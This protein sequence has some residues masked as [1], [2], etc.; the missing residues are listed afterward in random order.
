MTSTPTPTPPMPPPEDESLF[1]HVGRVCKNSVTKCFGCVQ[2][3]DEYAKIK[4]K[5]HQIDSRK[6]AFGVAYMNLILEKA[7]EEALNACLEKAQAEIA[8]FAEE[9]QVLQAEIDRVNQST[10]EKIVVKPGTVAAS[11]AVPAAAAAAAV[12]AAA[13]PAAVPAAAA[14][15]AA[16]AAVPAAAPAAVAPAAPAVAE[17]PRMEA[18]AASEEVGLE[19]VKLGE[20]TK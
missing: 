18:S 6:K 19:D 3:S 11:A 14:P 15:A 12:P 5:E 9:I 20:A 4:Y 13:A 1:G 8:V 16:P 7:T 10:K 2:T 17:A